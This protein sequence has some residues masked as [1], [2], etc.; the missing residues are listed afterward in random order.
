MKKHISRLKQS[1]GETIGSKTKT[2]VGADFKQLEQETD[3]RN[4]ATNN[5]F[6][7]VSLYLHT[8]SKK[9]D[10]NK[11]KKLPIEHLADS[12]RDY[13]LLLA[14]ESLYGK[15]LNSLSDCLGQLSDAQNEY[16][17]RTQIGIF[18]IIKVTL[19]IYP[20]FSLI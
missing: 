19:P 14:E 13:S 6:N 10:F 1:L 18:L 12:C 16:V 15:A 5:L 8:L 4:T 17:G 11:N 3:A 9:K 2:E 20:M 7:S